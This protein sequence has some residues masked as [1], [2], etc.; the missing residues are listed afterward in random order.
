MVTTT[1]LA[2]ISGYVEIDLSFSLTLQIA[3]VAISNQKLL[4]IPAI[5]S[6]ALQSIGA[7]LQDGDPRWCRGS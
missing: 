7:A 3:T 6:T 2:T 5:K 1:T 4:H